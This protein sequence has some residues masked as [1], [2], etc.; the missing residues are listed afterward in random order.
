VGVVE[1]VVGETV[2][3]LLRQKSINGT[4]LSCAELM[5]GQALALTLMEMV[6]FSIPRV[7]MVATQGLFRAQSRP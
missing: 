3:V 5:R 4:P 2:E 6:A 7:A 1:E